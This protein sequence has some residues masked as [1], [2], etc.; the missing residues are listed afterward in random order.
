MLV[1]FVG[2]G[3]GRRHG[4]AVP[5][6]DPHRIEIFNGA[7]D[8]D[9]V[10]QVTHDLQFILF[11]TDHRFL[12]QDLA[13]RTH[14][15]CPLNQPLKFFTIVG[16]VSTGT[17]HRKGRANDRGKPDGLHN[18]NGLLPTMRRPALRHTQPD[19]LHGLLKCLSIL[20]LMD[21]LRRRTHKG[22]SMFLQHASLD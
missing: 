11:P 16:N 9:I 14:G 7:H 10:F 6:V 22:D 17:S 19:P 4:D 5:G 15:Q 13:H 1:F 2:Q 3:H 8:D 20:C 21:R 12:D 18:R